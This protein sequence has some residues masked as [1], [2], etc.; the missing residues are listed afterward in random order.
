[1]K[2]KKVTK[3]KFTL[4]KVKRFFVRLW[5]KICSAVKDLCHR[6]MSLPKKVR[7]IIYV[8]IVVIL[9]IVIIIA[10][11]SAN[12]KF[13]NQYKDYEELVNQAALSYVKENK[14]YP[15][16]TN[17][18][19]LDINALIDSGLLNKN[20]IEDKTCTGF[21]VIYTKDNVTDDYDTNVEY[22]VHSYL[23]CDHYTTKGYGD[24]K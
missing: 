16:E 2:E 10:A 7:L 24:Y 3:K 23:N 22:V 17:K 5:K 4:K 9:L 20:S 8:W 19:F 6:F 18:L 15:M 12:N 1:M 11:S 21:A 13:L 14:I